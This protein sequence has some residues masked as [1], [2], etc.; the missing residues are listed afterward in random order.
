M[1][2]VR[3]SMACTTASV[4]L[5]LGAFALAAPTSADTNT[6]LTGGDGFSSSTVTVNAPQQGLI[7]SNGKPLV[8]LRCLGAGAPN[9]HYA[10][11]VKAPM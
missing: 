10:A 3:R 8:D 7:V 6:V 2:C 4:L 1:N 9:D 5:T 11:C